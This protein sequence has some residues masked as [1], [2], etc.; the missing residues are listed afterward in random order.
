[1][2]LDK[3][4]D[5][6]YNINTN[7]MSETK[8]TT[9][10]GKV[11][12]TNDNK[13]LISILTHIGCIFFFI[14]PPLIVY[15]VSEDKDVKE[16]AKE[17]LNFEISIAIYSFISGILVFVLIGILGLVL[18]G[19]ANLVLPILAALAVSEGK[20]YKYPFIFRLIK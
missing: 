6:S 9:A 5:Q 18:I 14:F 12:T 16:N 15:L 11:E 7:F 17:A 4:L 13:K 2:P 3:V 10:T 19:L 1:M 20:S 8:K